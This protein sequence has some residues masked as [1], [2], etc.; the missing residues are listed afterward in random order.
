MCL[1]SAK[2]AGFASTDHQGKTLNLQVIH[3][4]IVNASHA[5][6]GSSWNAR[7]G[8]VLA[9]NVLYSR[10]KNAINFANGKE[11]VTI[12]GNVVLGSG[13]REGTVRGR[14][15][16]DFINL[17]WDGEKYDAKPSATAP[18]AGADAKYAVELDFTGAKRTMLISGLCLAFDHQGGRD[19][20]AF[21]VVES[22]LQLKSES[23]SSGRPTFASGRYGPP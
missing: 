6:S 8:M 2:G 16:D 17:T 12:T 14:G 4:T 9:N 3:N 22:L 19:L 20:P 7:Q 1:I 13:P 21:L 10:D 18:F 15:L 11:G 23:H 5:F